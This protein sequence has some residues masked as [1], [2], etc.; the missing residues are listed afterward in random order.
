[1]RRRPPVKK[2][3]GNENYE[4]QRDVIFDLTEAFVC[5]NIPL[6]KNVNP[7]L[8]AVLKKHVINVSAVYL[9][10]HYLDA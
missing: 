7:K 3:K 10:M 9:V 4:R 1:M 5:A 6:E 2:R 8:C